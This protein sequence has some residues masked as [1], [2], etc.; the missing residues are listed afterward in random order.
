MAT[1]KKFMEGM[2][3]K[4]RA[5]SIINDSLNILNKPPNVDLMSR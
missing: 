5:H 4:N 1:S 2:D 3:E